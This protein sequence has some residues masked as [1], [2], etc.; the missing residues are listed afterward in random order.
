[1]MALSWCTCFK[2]IKNELKSGNEKNNK[3]DFNHQGKRVLTSIESGPVGFVL[4][5]NQKRK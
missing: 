5:G 1:M 3:G 2:H 4:V